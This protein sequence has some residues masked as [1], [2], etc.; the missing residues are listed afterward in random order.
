LDAGDGAGDDARLAATNC[1]FSALDGPAVVFANGGGTTLKA[2]LK[3]CAFVPGSTGTVF[4]SEDT[5]T[6]L[7]LNGTTN[8][9][10][11]FGTY[12]ADTGGGGLT[13]NLTGTQSNKTTDALILS[14]GYHLSHGSPLINVYTLQAGDET[15]DR[16]NN[17]R[18]EHN[19][20]EI[21]ADE[22]RPSGFMFKFK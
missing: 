21:G 22:Y 18:P 14:D 3:Y 8:A 6:A 4:E 2:D 19:L 13:D 17:T 1:T 15:V 5:A 20:C 9:F 10:Y 7:T 11:E 16:D 12:F